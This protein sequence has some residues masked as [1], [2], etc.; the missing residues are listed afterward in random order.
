MR[1][2]EQRFRA[3]GAGAMPGAESGLVCRTTS[4]CKSAGL[5]LPDGSNIWFARWLELAGSTSTQGA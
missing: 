5:T 4:R 1:L 2:S 3:A